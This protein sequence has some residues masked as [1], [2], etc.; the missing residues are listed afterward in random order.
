[1]KTTKRFAAAVMALIIALSCSAVAFAAQ[2]FSGTV[3]EDITILSGAEIADG[4][5]FK[6]TVTIDSSAAVSNGTFEGKVINNGTIVG[7]TFKG[8]VENNSGKNKIVFIDGGISGGTFS[9]TVNNNNGA[10]IAGGTFNGTVNNKANSSLT[11]SLT[12]ALTSAPVFNGTVNNDGTISAG[13]FNGKVVNNGSITTGIFTNVIDNSNGKEIPSTVAAV[14]SATKDKKTT[15]TVQGTPIFTG[16]A[17]VSGSNTTFVLPKN[18]ILTLADGAELTLN[19]PCE[20]NGALLLDEGSKLTSTSGSLVDPSAG[21]ITVP[22]GASFTGAAA[23]KF[24]YITKREYT[25]TVESNVDK[26]EFTF[27]VAGSAYNGDNV[28]Y[29][30]DFAGTVSKCLVINSIKVYNGKKNDNN[31]IK[32]SADFRGSFTMPDGNVIIYIDCV[33]NHTTATDHKD[34]TCTEAG[35]DRTY[36]SVC[37]H[38][39]NTTVIPAKGHSFGPWTYADENSKVL[40]TRICSVCHHTEYAYVEIK[41]EANG[42]NL[43]VDYRSTLTFHANVKAEDG[44][45]LYWNVNGNEVRDDGSATYTVTEAKDNVAIKAV[46]KG[47]VNDSSETLNITVKHGFFDKIKAFFRGLFKSLPVYI[48]NV[49]Q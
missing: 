31:I 13:T 40:K 49:K 22:Q 42:K 29:L 45:V 39:L 4:T 32:S 20:I 46:V 48:D 35:Y 1:M 10:I 11:V 5:V 44:Y 19:C 27:T 2:S 28:G 25:I 33:A 37:Q 12:S 41:N 14:I 23:S 16:K 6:G 3:T 24:S 17:S 34:A 30:F 43:T 7:G 18:S 15:V 38:T 9:G 26:S 36:C 47:I 8:T 21:S